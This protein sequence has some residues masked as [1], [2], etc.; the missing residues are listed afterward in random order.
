MSFDRM[1]GNVDL[2]I[3]LQV[4]K[5]FRRPDH[6]VFPDTLMDFVLFTRRGTHTNVLLRQVDAP[7]SMMARADDQVMCRPTTERGFLNLPSLYE[8]GQDGSELVVCS[9]VFLPFKVRGWMR[10][11]G[12]VR[13]AIR[14]RVGS[15]AVV[16]E[17]D[18]GFAYND[19]ELNPDR[20]SSL[21]PERDVDD[22]IE[23]CRSMR[24]IASRPAPRR[25]R[26]EPYAQPPWS[27][28]L[29]ARPL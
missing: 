20:A 6:V 14:K 2:R 15:G 5:G 16:V 3:T 22:L 1:E 21:M 26:S 4:P 24:I 7:G 13:T 19:E 17:C 18:I 12:P 29:P 9:Y 25:F 27:P 10:P 8:R 28:P 23:V 11:R